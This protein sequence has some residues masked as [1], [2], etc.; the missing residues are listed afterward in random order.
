MYLSRHRSG[1]DG[2]ICTQSYCGMVPRAR[3]AELRHCLVRWHR[4]IGK[5]CVNFV[6]DV[7]ECQVNNSVLL[8]FGVIFAG[9]FVEYASWRWILWLT[10]ILGMT[11]SILAFVAVPPGAPRRHK[12]SWKRLDLIG[13]SVLTAGIILF[14]Y[15]VT[16]GSVTGWGSANV[17]A[18]LIISVAMVAGFFVWEARIDPELA[19]LPPRL[20]KYPN[21][22]I[23]VTIALMPFFWW[24]GREL[25]PVHAVVYMD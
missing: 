1:I 23:L 18:P 13:V 11:I 8:V 14:I 20:W 7:P 3:G 5:W 6:T 22:P 16:S 15:A 21:V 24:C 9:V 19:A 10:G 4:W 2:P 17:L 25:F 12:P